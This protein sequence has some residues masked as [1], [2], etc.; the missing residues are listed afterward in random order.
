MTPSDPSTDH[1]LLDGAV[2]GG[3]S[4]LVEIRP[5]FEPRHRN[6]E[7]AR[8]MY[9]RDREALRD[10]DPVGCSALELA[11]AMDRFLSWRPAPRR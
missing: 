11:D 9:R 8:H 4:T 6:W 3:E 10:Q 5:Q 2:R 7:S 1:L